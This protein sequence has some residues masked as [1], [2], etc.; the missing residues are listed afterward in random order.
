MS[1]YRLPNGCYTSDSEVYVDAWEDLL[2]ALEDKVGFLV[3]GFDPELTVYSED[4]NWYFTLPVWAAL[5]IL[6]PPEQVRYTS[7]TNPHP[8]HRFED[9][10]IAVLRD[11][12]ELGYN[13][14]VHH[15]ITY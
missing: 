6:D 5:R 15:Q 4:H 13:D 14:W 12:T 2:Q 11:E 9:W 7:E 10:R 8:V 3:S 1:G